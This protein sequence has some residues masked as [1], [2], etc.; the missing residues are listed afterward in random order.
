MSEYLFLNSRKVL[1]MSTY[2]LL[3]FHFTI[4]KW[5]TDFYTLRGNANN[6]NV[7]VGQ[8]MPMGGNSI[9]EKNN[10]SVFGHSFVKNQTFWTLKGNAKWKIVT[11]LPKAC[12]SLL[13]LPL[14]IYSILLLGFLCHVSLSWGYWNVLSLTQSEVSHSDVTAACMRT[15]KT[16]FASLSA[17]A[18]TQM[19]K[20]V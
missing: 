18:E 1:K 12:F 14:P 17:T 20:P 16:R 11:F 6:F 2:N 19:L 8:K 3:H 5:E 7:Y 10:P 9:E 13:V 15:I 4:C